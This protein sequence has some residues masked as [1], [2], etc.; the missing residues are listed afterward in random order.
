MEF[1][2]KNIEKEA[3]EK[4]RKVQ[5]DFLVNIHMKNTPATNS[6]NQ[7][8]KAEKSQEEK[9]NKQNCKANLP[10]CEEEG[11]AK[12]NSSQ[13]PQTSNSGNVQGKSKMY[14]LEMFPY[15]SG[16][17]H[18]GHVRNYTIGDVITRF[19]KLNGVEVLHPIGWDAFGL[20]AE[21]AAIEKGVH[22]KEWTLANIANMKEQFKA[23]G[24]NFNWEAEVTTCLPNYYA[25]S[26]SMFLDFLANGIA[27]RKKSFVNWDPIDNTVLANEQV[28]DGHGW[29]SGALVEQ[30]ELNQ[31]F[32]K[33][34]DFS[35]NLL[36]GLNTL[37]D[38]PEKVRTMQENW[39]GKSQGAEVTFKI[40]EKS[41]S[42]TNVTVFTTRPE[43][44]FGAAFVAIS[45][46]HP[47]AIE[48][49]KTNKEIEAFCKKC[50]VQT[51]KDLDTQEKEGIP[52]GID[53]T[54][55][56]N[57]EKVPLWI[58]NFVLM[59]YG[60]GA[61]FG[62]PAHDERD[63]EFATKY[64]LPIKRVVE[65]ETELPYTEKVGKIINS[66]FLN[67]KSV[68]EGFDEAINFLETNN[69]GKRKI[70]YKLRD[71]GISRQRYWGCPIPII[72]CEACGVVPVPK[73]QLPVQLPEDVK[74]ES[75][76]NPLKK[77]PTW[78][79]CK[80]P[81]CGKDA[82]RETDTF[83]TFFESSWYFLRFCSP[84]SE[85][86]F[87]NTHPVDLYIGGVE[88]AILHLLYSRFF[89]M[90]L[91]KCRYK[92]YNEEPFKKLVTQGMV[93]HKTYRKDGKWLSPEEAK[94]LDGVEVGKS[95][96]MSK[97]KKNIVSPVEII[98]KYGADT[99][100]FFIISD[101]PVDRDFDWSDTGISAANKFL[102]KVWRFG[103]KLTNALSAPTA[104][105]LRHPSDATG[106]SPIPPELNKVLAEYHR[107]MQNL[108]LNKIIANLYTA[109]AII[110]KLSQEEQAS[111]F[112][113]FLQ[114]LFPVTP[115]IA[116]E[117]YFHLFNVQI[118]EIPFP[119]ATAIQNDIWKVTVQVNG[120]M[121][122]ILEFSKEPNQEEV[123]KLAS[124]NEKLSVLI[125]NAKKIIFIK[126]KVLNIV[127]NDSNN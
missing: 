14:I 79:H 123:I 49:S 13:T 74:I 40:A 47:I 94:E 28:I 2:H 116:H 29:R 57:G 46:R 63:F 99:A 5:E 112:G 97:S 101:S 27:Y 75:G 34:S 12:P 126:G 21:N 62:C 39:I 59:E 124:K 37:K 53:V 119:Q 61:V 66:C 76:E 114:M 93:C 48:L 73:E 122:T 125:A 18:M 84:K 54:N 117:L 65:S 50:N 127:A 106:N 22:P 92:I 96:K 25:H 77:H 45:P 111:A 69:V 60:T 11:Q 26:Q 109:F 80:C 52:T 6:T 110:E 41:T 105:R 44:L 4:W 83:D 81:T 90:A 87:E 89:V 115:H 108:F 104:L 70:T 35:Q 72:Y 9:Q 8:S 103:Q 36:E 58:A 98:E 118:T 1:N 32:L 91:R 86:P 7:E 71:W 100:R 24:F 78:K 15:P 121:K 67:G 17:L 16:N 42:E 102:Q 55:P 107:N 33:V 10:N 30:K 31:W 20:P 56:I 43:T 3:Q 68:L 82:E 64:N 88:H 113:A 19:Q 95:I 51:Q 23:L 38:W 85:K 120:K